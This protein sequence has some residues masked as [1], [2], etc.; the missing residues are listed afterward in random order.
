MMGVEYTVPIGYRK[1]HAAV[2][3]AELMLARE[4][5]IMKEQQR[6][7]VSHLS[8]AVADVARAFQ[9]VQNNLNQYLAAQ[10]YFAA[11]QNQKQE[12]GLEVES[13]RL[14]DAQRRVVNS[15]IQFFRARAEY[16]V[17]LKNFQYEKG[18]LLIY[19]DLRIAG[20][21]PVPETFPVIDER[22]LDEAPA[23][24][25]SPEV[26]GETPS[27][28]APEHK[29]ARNRRAQVP[30]LKLAAAAGVDDEQETSVG[31]SSPIP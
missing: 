5:M 7:I 31:D 11:L 26:N 13:D 20:A 18:A 15:E 29:S 4:R 16:A 3:H 23:P 2:D 9:A 30:A 19:K 27:N 14:L 21:G 6:E 1:A 10:N 24:V 28:V 17:S 12:Q 25:P 22:I 8:G